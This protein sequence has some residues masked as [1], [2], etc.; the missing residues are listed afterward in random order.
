MGGDPLG[1]VRAEDRDAVRDAVQLIRKGE[2]ALAL[3]PIE[4]DIDRIRLK[5]KV[6]LDEV[7]KRELAAENDPDKG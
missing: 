7:E 4:K 6:G 2:H 5:L 1:A 3:D